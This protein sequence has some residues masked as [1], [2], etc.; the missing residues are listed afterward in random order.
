MANGWTPE[1]R[2]RQAQL[3]RNWQ[4]WSR[5]TGPTTLEGKERSSQNAFVHGAY[6]WEAKACHK[7]VAL[8]LRDC[9]AFIRQRNEGY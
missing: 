2:A 5:S 1:R 6:N 9:R 3:I 8:L 4:P 7:R